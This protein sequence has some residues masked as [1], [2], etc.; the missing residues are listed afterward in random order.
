MKGRWTVGLASVLLLASAAPEKRYDWSTADLSWLND[1]A[2]IQY[3]DS[4]AI[5]AAV[6]GKEPPAADRPSKSEAAALKDCD[7]EALYFG[8][9]VR[10]DPARARKCAFVEAGGADGMRL[11]PFTGQGMLMI[12]Y[13]NGRGAARDL[14][15]TTH[16][17]C[18]LEDAP[19]E[20]DGRVLRLAKLRQKGWQGSDFTPC[21]DATSGWLGG[22]CTAHEKR[23]E[24]LRRQRGLEAITKTWPEAKLRDFQEVK[25]L[26]ESYV[27]AHGDGEVD[28]SGTLRTAIY[29]GETDSLREE[30]L[31]LLGALEANRIKAGSRAD[32]NRS[33]RRLNGTYRTLLGRPKLYWS[34][35]SP[36]PESV[37]ATE[38]VWIA[39]R[40]A[41]LN[42][43]ATHYP[44]VS[45]AGLAIVLTDN[46]RRVLEK[47]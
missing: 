37:R 44:K 26:H 35:P 28:L 7:S 1:D 21:D 8:I 22:M 18:G 10:A 9:G 19:A 4:R 12:I 6:I 11:G 42:F 45:R 40:D 16:L 14:D 2:A 33:D 13:A 43:A 34:D 32:L 38:R 36:S 17:A 3:R 46:R 41:M 5:C 39:Y 25:R 30:F 31:H 47:I 23:F 20:M 24:D 27:E 15:T 29:I